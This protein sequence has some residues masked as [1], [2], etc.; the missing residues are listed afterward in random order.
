MPGAEA[1]WLISDANKYF[2]VQQPWVLQ[3]EVRKPVSPV[4]H[5]SVTCE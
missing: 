3:S 5:R 4:P 1:I 2:S